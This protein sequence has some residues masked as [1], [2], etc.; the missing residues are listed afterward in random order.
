MT[1]L[2]VAVVWLLLAACALVLTVALCRAGHEED[3]QRHYV[4]D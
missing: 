1:I 2:A 4:D 3:V